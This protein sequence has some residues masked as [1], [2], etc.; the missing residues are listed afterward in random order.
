MSEAKDMEREIQKYNESIM[1]RINVKNSTY[2]DYVYLP[3]DFDLEKLVLESSC[4]DAQSESENSY[5][6]DFDRIK[7]KISRLLYKR[8]I[9]AEAT[10]FHPFVYR[11]T[12]DM[13]ATNR[14][15]RKFF[16]YA[17]EEDDRLRVK[18]VIIKDAKILKEKG[19]VSAI[20]KD[21]LDLVSNTCRFLNAG[22][23]Y[24]SFSS[25]LFEVLHECTHEPETKE[26]IEHG[27]KQAIA[28]LKIEDELLVHDLNSF[29][30]ELNNIS[31]DVFI[32]K[33]CSLPI[34][35]KKGIRDL[36]DTIVA[37]SN[38]HQ[39]VK[40]LVCAVK[41]FVYESMLGFYTKTENLGSKIIHM[42]DGGIDDFEEEVNKLADEVLK[43]ELTDYSDK[44]K[45]VLTEV[46]FDQWAVVQGLLK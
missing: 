13:S 32:D 5:F 34:D 26:K 8:P 22:L 7:Q 2:A 46:S 40:G 19:E 16:S 39:K 23:K 31:L 6:I 36:I 3:G 17:S 21:Y 24:R 10:D 27:L 44:L 35:A 28:Q 25:P 4:F 37:G 11:D 33:N 14:E 15:V 20:H 43:E 29:S 12:R 9:Q 45:I 38:K 41:D 42:G 30:K 1:G 18:K